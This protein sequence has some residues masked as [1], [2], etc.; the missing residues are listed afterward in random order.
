MMWRY[1][2]DLI[3]WLHIHTTNDSLHIT[4]RLSVKNN[5]SLYFTFTSMTLHICLL[6][7]IHQG[8]RIFSLDQEQDH[9]LPFGCVQSNDKCGLF[10]PFYAIHKPN[11]VPPLDITKCPPT[12]SCNMC[13]CKCLIN[14]D[15]HKGSLQALQVVVML[16]AS[17]VL[18]NSPQFTV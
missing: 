18:Q 3:M 4:I 10:C 6:I 7:T 14:K 1:V 16:S 13:D 9:F 5:F 15:V 17:H 12:I 2:Y 11:F 8:M